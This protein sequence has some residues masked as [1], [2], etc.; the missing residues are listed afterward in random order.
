M[1]DLAFGKSFNMLVDGVKHFFMTS[2]HNNMF[3]IT[4]IGHMM[5]LFPV[6]KITPGV[7]F[8]YLRFRKW[9]ENQIHERM[10]VS[11]HSFYQG[12]MLILEDRTSRNVQTY[13]LGFW[14]TIE[15]KNHQP[16]R[17]S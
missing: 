10:A 1:G 3:F 8:E 9:I 7:N 6:I 14:R 12:A 11:R 2:L 13:S 15:R 17:T 5:W 16:S 4:L